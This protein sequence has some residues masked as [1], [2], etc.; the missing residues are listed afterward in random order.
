MY[1]TKQLK[2]IKLALISLSALKKKIREAKDGRFMERDR[3]ILE[4]LKSLHCQPHPFFQIYPSETDFSKSRFILMEGPPDTPYESGVF[5]L[6]C[7][8]GPE[9]P[10]KPPTVRFI[11]FIYHC[12]INNVG[13]ICHNIFDR[14]YNA[15]IT[16]REILNAVY[17][18]LMD[19][20][21]QDPLDRNEAK[22]IESFS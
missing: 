17:G 3:R 8:F 16:M 18:L 9:Y 22:L 4:E 6:F 5:E 14:G 1:W 11:T 7:Q 21:P 15:H 13:R 12:N 20:E 2:H 19:P 10:V